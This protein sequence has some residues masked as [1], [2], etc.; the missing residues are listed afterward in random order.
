MVSLSLSLLL[1]IR[2][3]EYNFYVI[4]RGEHMRNGY[5]VWLLSTGILIAVII[6]AV[7][8][9]KSLNIYKPESTSVM[10]QNIT[11]DGMNDKAD[12]KIIS[13][14]LKETPNYQFYE[15]TYN[16]GSYMIFLQEYLRNSEANLSIENESKKEK[17]LQELMIIGN[18]EKQNNI[19]H[20][21]IDGREIAI[22]LL[23]NIYEIYGVNIEF[24]MDGEIQMIDDPLGN[25]IYQNGDKTIKIELQVIHLS[26]VVFLIFILFCLSLFIARKSKILVKDGGIDGFDEKKYA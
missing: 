21:S 12:E 9:R 13:I 5:I 15:S 11:R 25:I 19:Q 24:G 10:S 4:C 22:S 17:L 16:L 18:L 2:E 14:Q 3:F 1:Y 26:I 20:M 8:G 7:G 23:K 6:I